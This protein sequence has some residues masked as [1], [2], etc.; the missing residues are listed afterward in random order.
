MLRAVS[1]P[2]MFLRASV[3]WRCQIKWFK[4]I[5]DSLDDPFIFDLMDRFG[6]DGYL[7]FF[8]VLEIY[9]REFKTKHDWKLNVTRSY[10]SRKLNKRQSTLVMKCLKH[11]Q[12]SGK[13]EITFNDEQVIVFIP[14]F[15]EIIGEWTRRKLRSPSAD[16]PKILK[17][18]EE[19][20]EEAEEDIPLK[21]KGYKPP[22]CPQKKIIGL[23]HKILPSLPHIESW[24]DASEN[25]LRTRWREDPKRQIIENWAL[26]RR[27]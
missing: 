12:K 6:A 9:S 15:T 16:A 2:I 11:I 18:E 23:Y 3:F 14:K 24:P 27:S 25:H 8:G 4:H 19:A 5:S 13:W 22:P 26:A 21:G 1:Q 7:V 17:T 20:E 10:L